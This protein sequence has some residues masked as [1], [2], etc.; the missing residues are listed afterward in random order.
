LNIEHSAA[1]CLVQNIQH[2]ILNVQ[3][4]MRTLSGVVTKDAKNTTNP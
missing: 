4:Q 2:S 1:K 3:C